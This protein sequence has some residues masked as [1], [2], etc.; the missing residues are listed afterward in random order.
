MEDEVRVILRDAAAEPDRD[1]T[2]RFTPA[3]SSMPRA[4]TPSE[5]G[6]RILVIIGG[7]VAAYKSL[8]L[9]PRLQER[10]AQL[11]CILTAAAQHFFTP[12]SPRALICARPLSALF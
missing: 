12:L 5:D 11:R 10:G 7:G 3:A 1:A 4:A 8:D 6:P 2:D 9:I